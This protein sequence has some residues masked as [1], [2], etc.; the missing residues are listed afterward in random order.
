VRLTKVGTPVTSSDGNDAQLGDD[1]GGANRRG[2]FL[3]CLDAKT[4]VS[5]RVA[6]DDNSLESGTL[7]GAGLL[8]DGLDLYSEEK[9]MLDHRPNIV[10]HGIVPMR[11]AALLRARKLNITMRKDG[12]SK[13]HLHDLILE[14]GEEVVHNLKL[15]DGQ[16]VQINLLHVANLAS[17]DKPAELGDGLPFFLVVLAT[18]ATTASSST[19]STA[20]VTASS[21]E[22]TATITT[23]AASAASRS[24]TTSVSHGCRL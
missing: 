22:S 10:C 4:D 5:L 23:S 1:D 13:T 6:D 11:R 19:S 16:G 8:L 15:L 24:S 14:F 17:L 21:S 3:R 2:N 20:A 12:F 7:T 18:S 9:R